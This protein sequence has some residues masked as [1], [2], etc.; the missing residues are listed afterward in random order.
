MQTFTSEI[1][2]V[3]G[4]SFVGKGGGL[5]EKA[6]KGSQLEFGQGETVKTYIHACALQS[7]IISKHCL[8]VS[9]TVHIVL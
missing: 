5:I 7:L 9:D 4:Q 6:A 3:F 8:T 2:V 1:L